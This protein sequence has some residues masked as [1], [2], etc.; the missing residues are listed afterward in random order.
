MGKM[1]SSRDKQALDSLHKIDLNNTTIGNIKLEYKSN[2]YTQNFAI[3][4]KNFLTNMQWLVYM[5]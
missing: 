5:S 2:D 4:M 3:A 1:E